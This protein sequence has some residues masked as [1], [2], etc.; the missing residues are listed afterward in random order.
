MIP[1]FWNGKRVFL[2]G[3]TGFKGAW[4]ALWLSRM[5]AS[6][7]GYALPAATEP[8]LYQ[9]VDL[10]SHLAGETIADICNH[11]ALERAI[12]AAEPEVVIH[13]A[14]QALVRLSY[15]EPIETFATNVIGTAKLLDTLRRIGSVRAVVVVT[16]DKCYENEDTGRPFVETDP[17]GGRDPYSASK[18]CQEIVTSA[19]RASF[20]DGGALIA[21]ARAGNVLGGG[22]WAEDRLIPDIVRASQTGINLTVRYPDAVRPWQYVLDPLAGYLSLAEALYAGD[23]RC[24][25]AWNFAPLSENAISVR[26]VIEEFLRVYGSSVIVEMD[27]T[28]SDHESH[29]LRLDAGKAKRLLGWQPKCDI[30]TTI[31]HTANWYRIVEDGT[32]PI[33]ACDAALAVAMADLED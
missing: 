10:P 21:T 24:A 22:D 3:H 25:D 28:P 5:G 2:T 16:T 6:V 8:S 13:M 18:A 9:L 1:G 26:S 29:L 11:E 31:L 33:V 19:M 4:T 15:R 12:A 17:L 20:F 7:Y 32:A 14:A 30:A 27:E 23:V